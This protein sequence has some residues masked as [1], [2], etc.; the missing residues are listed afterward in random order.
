V[1]PGSRTLFVSENE[2][3]NE[4]TKNYSAEFLELIKNH[5]SSQNRIQKENDELFQFRVGSDLVLKDPMNNKIILDMDKPNSPYFRKS[6]GK[7]DLLLKSIG[8]GKG[9]TRVLDLSAGL[10]IDSFHFLS[11]GLQVTA[12]ERSP[13]VYFLLKKALEK[14][15]RKEFINSL[16]LIFT[17][18]SLYLKSLKNGPCPFDVIYFDPM[19]SERKKSALPKQEMVLFHKLVGNDLDARE[20]FDLALSV[21]PQRVVVKRHPHLPPLSTGVKHSFVGKAVRYDYY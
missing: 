1:I 8:L 5:P 12:L 15:S 21:R 19:Y 14:S 10:L 13:E 2:S 9:V 17:E 3:Y 7:K 4:L 18:A 6:V 16:E 20:I 11:A